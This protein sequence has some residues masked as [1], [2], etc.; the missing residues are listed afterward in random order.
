MWPLLSGPFFE[1][2]S[3]SVTR[4]K[5]GVQWCD[6]GSLQPPPP[7]F[8]RFFCLSLPSS[9]D[10]RHPPPCPGNFCIFSKEGVSP[11]WPGW[12]Q[13]PDLRWSA[14]LCPHKVLG[15]FILQMSNTLGRLFQ[16]RNKMSFQRNEHHGYTFI[17]FLHKYQCCLLFLQFCSNI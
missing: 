8:K 11:C 4:C 16:S 6:L 5:A 9:W 17:I 3:H 13:T 12:S 2:E 14:F 7:G 10:Y 1:T 15:L